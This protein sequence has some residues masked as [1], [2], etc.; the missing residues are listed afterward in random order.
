[1]LIETAARPRGKGARIGL[2]SFGVHADSRG[3]VSL[4]I[5]AL[6]SLA[7]PVGLEDAG[8]SHWEGCNG[9]R[10]RNP[11]H[12]GPET[13]ESQSSGRRILAAKRILHVDLRNAHG[14]QNAD[15][16]CAN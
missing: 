4:G 3:Q 13:T 12:G 5:D 7:E 9:D 14:W 16:R 10:H 15:D 8:G 11:V 2:V 1:E 6:R